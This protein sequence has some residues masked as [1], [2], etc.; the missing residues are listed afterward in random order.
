MS[1]NTASQ[2][3]INVIICM[4]LIGEALGEE[5]WCGAAG[6]MRHFPRGS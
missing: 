2:W 4:E 1:T 3:S 5:E 6:M